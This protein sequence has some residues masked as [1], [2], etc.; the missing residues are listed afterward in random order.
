MDTNLFIKSF[1]NPFFMLPQLFLLIYLIYFNQVHA[2][3]YLN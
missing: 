2:L 3:F 1:V